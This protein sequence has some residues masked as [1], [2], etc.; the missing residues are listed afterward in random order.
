VRVLLDT[1]VLSEL[2]RN[3]RAHAKVVAWARAVQTSDMFISA[4]TLLEIEIGALRMERRDKKQG[5]ALRTWIDEQVLPDF[6]GRIL[7]V[8]AAVALQC[9]VLQ[10]PDPRPHLDA[11]IAATALVHRMPLA[12][13]N[14][15]DFDGMG[16]DLINP[17]A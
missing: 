13:R 6:E 5:A 14:I 9:A 11:L 7:L 2:R 12:T 8:D 4:I 17:W 1:N 3:D 16:L 15:A 10:V